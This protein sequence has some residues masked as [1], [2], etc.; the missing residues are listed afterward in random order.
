MSDNMTISGGPDGKRPTIQGSAIAVN[1]LVIPQFDAQQLKLA[2][3]M[4]ALQPGS[5]RD[6]G[7]IAVF[8]V[9]KL[10]KVSFLEHIPRFT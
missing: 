2:V 9:D 10:F 8:L 6:P 7:H 4:S 1:S 5:F 3:K